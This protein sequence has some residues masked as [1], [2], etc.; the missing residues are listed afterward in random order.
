[1]RLYDPDGLEKRVTLPAF[2]SKVTDSPAASVNDYSPTGWNSSVS[3]LELTPATGGTVLT[4]L[5]ASVHQ[6]GDVVVVSN[7]ASTVTD[8][9]SFA[10]ESA[11]S[12]AVNRFTGVGGEDYDLV[13]GASVMLL[14]TATRWRFLA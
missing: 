13:P 11:S 8:S 12:L 1:M 7:D 6:E 5:D 14:R 3:R 10:N 9:V 2:P 4:G